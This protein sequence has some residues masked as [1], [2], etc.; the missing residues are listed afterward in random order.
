MS[1]PVRTKARNVIGVPGES[2][3]WTQVAPSGHVVFGIVEDGVPIIQHL[4][5]PDDADALAGMLTRDAEKARLR[6]S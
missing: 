5:E 2:G 4:L 6:R 3:Y 1:E